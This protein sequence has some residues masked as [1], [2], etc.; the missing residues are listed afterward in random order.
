MWKKMHNLFLEKLNKIAKLVT[1]HTRNNFSDIVNERLFS[2]RDTSWPLYWWRHTSS[3]FSVFAFVEWRC[4]TFRSSRIRVHPTPSPIQGELRST[5]SDTPCLL[6]STPPRLKLVCLEYGNRLT[7]FW[8]GLRGHF[9]RPNCII[10]YNHV[11]LYVYI[12][13]IRYCSLY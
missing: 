13:H 12:Q 7:D 4:N 10:S 1:L 9:I 8:L 6:N 11:K 3:I 2:S 5:S